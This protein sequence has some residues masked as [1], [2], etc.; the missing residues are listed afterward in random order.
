MTIE[1]TTSVKHMVDEAN[2]E[3]ETLPVD[4]A[5]PSTPPTMW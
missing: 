4:D 3:I 1:I 2:A 5:S